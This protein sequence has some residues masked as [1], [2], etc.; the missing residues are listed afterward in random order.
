[1]AVTHTIT[2]GLVHLSG[3]P[4]YIT[5][6]ASS[7]RFNHRLALK[8]TRTTLQGVQLLGSPSVEEIAP[9]NLVSVFDISGLVD[10]PAQYKFDYPATGATSPYDLL[11]CRV[12]IDIGEVWT[13]TNGKRQ[14]SWQNISSNHQLRV[15]K[16][17]LRQYELSVLNEA[18]KSFASE[19]INGG[20]FL[21]HLPNFQKVA[22]NHI[23]RLWYLSRWTSNHPFTAHLRVTTTDGVVHPDITQD[24]V[25]YDITGLVEFAFQPLFWNFNQAPGTL[26]DRYEFWLTDS[27]GDISEHRTYVVDNGYYEESFTLFYV[28]PFSG[29]DMIWL[30]GQHSAGIKIE[31]ETAFRPVAASSG[32][33]VASLKTISSSSQRT[34]EINTGVKTR[35]EMDAL[36]DFLEAKECWLVDPSNENSLI[37]VVVENGDKTLY[38]SS[39]DI[40]HL[41]VKLQEAHR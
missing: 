38:S 36:R 25:F 33:K 18:S 4:I 21:T 6:T 41:T 2:G 34:W 40:H 31:S 22:P 13:D 17:K 19:Y 37:P 7:A 28:N 5:L 11:A 20:K 14:E 27:G 9:K 10:Y 1:M 39:E 23:P 16:G 32:T 24:F 3:N 30:T 8:V 29:I 12:T 15:I 35:A 26:I